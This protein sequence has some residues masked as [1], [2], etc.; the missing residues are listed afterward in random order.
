[1]NTT[2]TSLHSDFTQSPKERQARI[3]ACQELYQLASTKMMCEL[4]PELARHFGPTDLTLRRLFESEVRTLSTVCRCRSAD[5]SKVRL[6]LPTEKQGADQSSVLLRQVSDTYLEG[7]VVLMDVGDHQQEL[8]KVT[9]R[10]PVGIH[11]NAVISSSMV[12]LNARV[13]RNTCV[14]NSYIGSQAVVIH[15]GTI[16]F[17]SDS[18]FETL[19]LTVGP[20]SGGGRQLLVRP[21]ERLP[22][23]VDQMASCQPAEKHETAVQPTMNIFDQRTMVR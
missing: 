21:E 17:D 14:A 3:T 10:L 4:S 13:H 15:N 6:V 23:V 8:N 11:S 22:A 7:T 18:S 2:T 1:M 9:S 20:E 12:F 5:W 19:S 16:S